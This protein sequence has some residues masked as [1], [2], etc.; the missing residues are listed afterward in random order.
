[1]DCRQI[2]LV[3][4]GI[5]ALFGT[6]AD[7]QPAESDSGFVI[8]K[9]VV[10]RK[11]GVMKRGKTAEFS[12]Q[13]LARASGIVSDP[14]RVLQSVPGVSS[15]NDIM[16]IPC[17]RSG[18]PSEFAA[19]LNGIP[20]LYP[21]HFGGAKSIFNTRTIR[22]MALYSS[23]PPA[24]FPAAQSG[25]LSLETNRPSTAGGPGMVA[26]LNL[27]QHNGYAHFPL[28]ANRAAMDISYQASNINWTKERLEDLL[29]SGEKRLAD[30]TDANKLVQLPEYRDLSLG[31]AWH[32]SSRSRL[33]IHGSF[34]SNAVQPVLADSMVHYRIWYPEGPKDVVKRKGEEGVFTQRDCGVTSAPADSF[35]VVNR[36]MFPDTLFDY[37]T[38]YGILTGS[39]QRVLGESH[40]LTTRLGFQSKAWDLDFF[41]KYAPDD[42]PRFE[43]E[44]GRL[45]LGQQWL[46]RGRDDR[47]FRMGVE[48]GRQRHE[49][50]VKLDRLPHQV[51]TQGTYL[52]GDQ[53]GKAFSDKGVRLDNAELRPCLEEHLNTQARTFEPV[54]DAKFKYAGMR[55]HWT[56]AAYFQADGQIA[57]PIDLSMGMR[58]ET[59]TRSRILSHSPRALLDWRIT[60]SQSVQ[61]GVARILQPSRN[62]SEIRLSGKLQPEAS[63]HL[64]VA[65][66]G[67]HFPWLEQTTSLYWKKYSNQI[68]EKIRAPRLSEEQ[69]DALTIDFI[70][71]N[72]VVRRNVCDTDRTRAIQALQR[73][74]ETDPDLY[75]R[76]SRI[77]V[78]SKS[79]LVPSFGNE[80]EGVSKGLETGL[81]VNANSWLD[82]GFSL[83]LDHSIRRNGRDLP[84]HPATYG[85]P[86]VFSL[87]NT[88]GLPVQS[89]LMV[90]YQYRAGLPYTFFQFND[91]GTVISTTNARRFAPYVRMDLKLS[92]RFSLSGHS[93]T[94]YSEFWN[95]TNQKNHLLRDRITGKVKRMDLNVP[96]QFVFAGMTLE[97]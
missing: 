67:K 72:Y 90:K 22:N 46:I 62:F 45:D 91:Q 82:G 34:H 4:A 10:S 86:V 94:A 32:L 79:S 43:A 84:Y 61:A 5:P 68:V 97:W 52:Y 76:L 36:V 44:V 66:H 60:P 69:T 41:D 58:T 31:G 40:M 2:A 24:S 70:H 39:W 95:V 8:Q 35:G 11:K 1:M 19:V 27:L 78:A 33:L 93:V 56:G 6:G 12:R 92:K 88:F 50:D 85:R 63:T 21:Y 96:S 42:P 59:D 64:N 48:L 29:K 80:G 28:I 47:N 49:Y 87:W 73:I 26:D 71:E 25:I 7:G 20:V 16:S 81:R 18:E 65:W 57:G 53:W 23:I 54:L 74:K 17:I 83:A 75:E 14:I 13:E 37:S 30:G 3:I 77:A 9:V 55:S 89:D 15:S 38:R 51:L